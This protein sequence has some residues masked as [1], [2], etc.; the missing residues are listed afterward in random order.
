M[1]YSVFNVGTGAYDYYEDGRE[2]SSVNT[3]SPTHVIDRTLGCTVDQAAWPLPADAKKIGTGPVAIG[4]VASMK[5]GGALGDVSLQSP[6][7]KAGV[8]L[9]AAILLYKYVVK[10]KRR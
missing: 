1:Q 9:G 4:R 6:M 10:G 8:L 3:P 5:R 2:P 7:A